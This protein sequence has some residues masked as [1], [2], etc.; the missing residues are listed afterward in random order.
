MVKMRYVD[1][2]PTRTPVSCRVN[3]ADDRP[4]E[5]ADSVVVAWNCR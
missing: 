4:A 3:D 5:V 2:P 1:E